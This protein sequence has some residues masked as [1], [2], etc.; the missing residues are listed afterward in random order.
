MKFLISRP[1]S[2][3]MA[4]LAFFV[5]G[6]AM[7]MSLPVSLL[8]DIAIPQITIQTAD[9]NMSAREMENSIIGPIRRSLLQVNGLE[10]IKSETRDGAG[11]I[12]MRFIFGTNTDYAYIEVNE[13]I[14]ASMN[15]L[16]HGTT[17]P[18]TIKASATDIPVFYI[19]IALKEN[20]NDEV[21][22][23]QMCDIV[24]NVIRR[25]V[26]QLPEVAMADMTGVPQSC[27]MVK[28]DMKRLHSY[29]LQ[30]SDID[31]ALSSNNIDAGKMNVKD[32]V[33]EY[34]VKVAT[35]LADQ[36]DVENIYIKVADRYIQIK[37][38]CEVSLSTS[39]E[40]G[41]S[42]ANGR[43]V[44]TLAVIKNS[45]EGVDALKQ[46]I[47]ELKHQFEVQFPEL[48]C[49]ICRNQT[50]LLDYSIGNLRQ[51]LI[52]GFLLIII[53]ATLFMGGYKPSMIVGI[54]MVA[55]IVITFVPFYIFGR[56][57]NIVSLSGLILVVGMMIDNALIVSD[58]IA[59]W[60][61]RGK[62]LRVACAG[63]T[64]EMIAP[65]LSSSLTTVAVFVPLIFIEGMAGS[66]FSDQAFAITAGLGVSYVVGIILLP[67]V[68][69]QIMAISVR[70]RKSVQGNTTR[71]G[72]I[73]KAYDKSFGWVMRH[74]M[75]V[76]I[77]TLLTLPL[78]YIMFGM[79]EKSRLPKIDYDELVAKVDWNEEI[80]VG[81]NRHR[82][83]SL[84]KTAQNAATYTTEYVGVQD[85]MT[86]ICGGMSKGQSEIYW[87]AI[88]PD[89]VEAIKS[90]AQRWLTSNHHG[91]QITFAP[92]TTIFEKLFNT[93]EPDIEVQ[94]SAKGKEPTPD[95]IRAAE[96]DIKKAAGK[97][98]NAT[99]IAFKPVRTLVVDRKALE[100]YGVK[101]S[102]LSSMLKSTIAESQ[103]TVLHSYS[104]YLPICLS[105]RE[106]TLDHFVQYG[107]IPVNGG[108]VPVRSLLHE[109]TQ[110]E[111]KTIY[112][113]K[114]GEYMAIDLY[115]VAEG[116]KRC[117]E[118]K[119]AIATEHDFE[120]EFSG[121]VF[122]N[123]KM[124]RQLIVI[125]CLSLMLM[126]FILCA[127]FESFRQPLIVLA[128]IPIDTSFALVVLYLCGETLNL[129]SGI[130]IV[131]SCG[132]IINDSIL[133]IDT[134]NELRR[135]G[136][137]LL[138]AVHTA[139]HRRLRSIVMTSLTTIGATLPILFTSDMGSELQRPLAIA[140]I[141]TMTIGTIVSLLVIP[142]IYTLIEKK[143]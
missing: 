55:S 96:R 112:G 119:R 2:V 13:K 76:L 117:E 92:P 70:K 47:E 90:R 137:P 53:V 14:D 43:R 25:R 5:I 93:A 37:D 69:R 10:D 72:A 33:Y 62:T 65:L 7:Y 19:N 105:A 136:M 125:L 88:S 127:Q 102:Q 16:P 68:Y 64:S 123:K 9:A 6:I 124:M 71:M 21:R 49:E 61:Q 139:G 38:V 108:Y 130:G 8:P 109:T 101:L 39:K 99:S 26:E 135:T 46:R 111:L 114:D 29:G 82:T 34:S 83:E 126:Y 77:T 28:P 113:G 106:E 12:T 40:N 142:L 11:T 36:E 120:A 84:S 95:E 45:A 140:M 20:A 143:R 87:K 116:D 27:L 31:M 35:L 3:I 115:G 89:S 133:K 54:T 122:S 52:L 58:N 60:H 42:M 73:M 56:S 57:L 129:M 141:A 30:L 98:D 17:R 81:E 74:R 91:A 59:Q 104:S 103:V 44:V 41:M 94:L 110:E 79:C 51:N 23:M 78:C 22:F 18:K 50:E 75:A 80:S 131:V 24:E 132:I 66:I 107:S 134:I 118:I 85:Y 128:E 138:E 48:T 63:A 97:I 15:S 67:V 4:F 100:L 121:S 1:I 86:D 32:G